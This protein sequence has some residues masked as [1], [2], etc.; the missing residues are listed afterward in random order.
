MAQFEAFAPGVEVSGEAVLSLLDAMAVCRELAQRIL[1]DH[2]IRDPKPGE[3]YLQQTWL[4][5]LR[6]I[7]EKVG[8]ATLFAMGKGAFERAKWPPDI[9]SLEKAMAF[10]DVAYHRNHRGGE[11]GSYQ[12]KS[13]GPKSGKMVCHTPYP[14]DFDRGRITAAARKFA[15]KGSF[16]QVT[17]DETASTRNKG[18]DSCTYLISW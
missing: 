18:A 14:P 10:V 1:A 12:F 9:D 4:D 15:P 3:W 17:L 2:G 16:L 6:T 5:A 11:I 7:A 13:T 8:S